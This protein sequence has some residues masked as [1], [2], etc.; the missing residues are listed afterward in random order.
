MVTQNLFKSSYSAT[1]YVDLGVSVTSLQE[2]WVTI[3]TQ[4]YIEMV[5]YY[6]YSRNVDISIEKNA[7]MHQNSR[8]NK[9]KMFSFLVTS[10]NIPKAPFGSITQIFCNKVQINIIIHLFFP[11]LHIMHKVENRFQFIPGRSMN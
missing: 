6:P 8:S 7:D 10:G 9:I 5:L 3:G 4:G 2:K 11:W 1:R